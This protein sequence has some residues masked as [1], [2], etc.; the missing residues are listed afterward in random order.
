MSKYWLL[1]LSLTL[2]Y[3]LTGYVGLLMHAVGTNVTLMWLPTGIAVAF[4]FRAGYRYWPAVSLG[5]LLVNLSVGSSLSTSLGIM[6]GN[7]AG[8]LLTTVLLHRLKFHS[9]M[10]RPLDIGLLVLA[11]H[12]GMLVSATNGVVSLVQFDNLSEGYFKAWFCWW[13]G[14]SMG[15]IVAGPILLIAERIELEELQQRA[16]E[17]ACWIF[18]Y[19]LV[20]LGVFVWNSHTLEPAWA[21]AFLPFPLIA[22]AT[23]RFG[24]LGASLSVLLLS[25]GAAYGTSIQSG[26]FYRSE[27]SQQILMLW[28]YMATTSTLAWLIAALHA[29]QLRAVNINRILED[30]LREASLG[31]LLTDQNR[32]ITYVNEGFTRLTQYSQQ[33]LLGRDCM[34]LQGERTDSKTVKELNQVLNGSGHFDG[35][36]LNYR[37]D[38]TAFWNGLLISPI[39]N[40]R[41]ERIGFLGIQRDITEKKEADFSLKMSEARLRTILELEPE[42]VKIVSPDGRLM[43]MNPAGLVMVEADSIDQVRGAVLEVL[44]DEEYRDVFRKLHAYVLAGGSGHGEFPI[45][46][47]KGSRRW[48]ETHAVPY[49]DGDGEIV[50]QLAVTLDITNRKKAEDTIRRSEERHRGIIENSSTGT[51]LYEFDR[52]IP[53]DLPIEEQVRRI[54]T[55]GSIAIANDAQARMYGFERGEQLIGLR[56]IDLYQTLDNEA[57]N[58]FLRAMVQ[59]GYQIVDAVSE[60][61][62]RKGDPVV[63]SNDCLGT[64]ENGHLVRIWGSQRDITQQHLFEIA[65]RKLLETTTSNDLSFEEQLQRILELGCSHFGAEKGTVMRLDGE[66]YELLQEWTTSSPVSSPSEPIPSAKSVFETDISYS[67]TR[68]GL[69]H[70]ESSKPRTVPYSTLDTDLLMLMSDWIGSQLRLRST[71]SRQR[72]I[73]EN[74]PDLVLLLDRE[75]RVE[76]I[77]RMAP[78]VQPMEIIGTALPELVRPRDREVIEKCLAEVWQGR[79]LGQ[80]E[81]QYSFDGPELDDLEGRVT[82]VIDGSVVMGLVVTFTDVTARKRAELSVRESRDR[83]DGILT[84]IQVVVYSANI[85]GDAI[86]F[87]SD[88]CKAIYGLSAAEFILDPLHWQTSVH[89]EDRPKVEEAFAALQT[90]GAFEQEYR[91][92]RPDGSVRWVYDCG[93][94]ILDKVGVPIRLDGVVSDITERKWAEDELK[95]SELRYREMFKSNP[96]PMWVYDLKTLRFLAVN[97]AAIRHYGYSRDEFLAMTIADIRP[98]ED[99]AKLIENVSKVAN[100]LDR[101]GIWRHRTKS[102]QTIEVEV[103]SHPIQYDDRLAEVVLA[104]DVTERRRLEEQ[105]RISQQRFQA[106]VERSHDL[107]INFDTAGIIQFVNPASRVVLGYEPEEMIGRHNMSF[108]FPADQ[109]SKYREAETIIGKPRAEFRTE[110]KVQHK[111]GSWRIL[112]AVGINLLDEPALAGLVVNCRDITERK[113]RETRSTNERMLLELLTSGTPIDRV[114][115]EVALSSERLNPGMMCSILLLEKDGLHLHHAAA[116]SLP[117][118]YCQ[119]IDMFPIGPLAGSC[120]RAAVL[121]KSVITAEIRTDPHWKEYAELAEQNGLKAC[122]SVP[123]ISSGGQVLGT[124]AM[125]YSEPR[126]PTHLELASVERSAQLAVLAVER[127]QLLNSLQESKVQ[128]ERLVGNLPGMAYRCQN[129]TQWTMIYVS[130]GCEAVTGYLRDE[131]EQNKLVDYSDLIHSEDRDWLWSKCQLALERRVPCSNIYRIVDRAGEVRWVQERATGV[132]TEDGTLQFVDGFIQDISESRLADER[133]RNALREKEAMLKE[134]H[135]RVKNN[136]QIVSSLLNLQ[137]DKVKDSAV[138]DGL[139]DSQ[140]RVRSMALVH[141][142]LYSGNLGR[143]DLTEYLHSLCRHL[144]RS[145]GVDSAQIGLVLNVSNTSLDLEQAIPL[146]LIINELVSNSL[147]YAFPDGGSGQIQIEF[148]NLGEGHLHLVVSDNGVGISESID[149]KQL[150]SLGLQLVHDLAHQLAGSVKIFRGNGTQ[151]CITFPIRDSNQESNS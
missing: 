26:P 141:E 84:S 143:I 1:F 112:E 47:L 138:F 128:L 5:S 49:R 16:V 147:K 115:N 150:S 62:D 118:S 7:T 32:R 140:N 27:V 29:A 92:V 81:I 72:A 35:A 110:I 83:I 50:G 9:K 45:T 52:P 38:G 96:H 42:C 89:P 33:E 75:N 124:F 57:N 103:T 93:R 114:L 14:D 136:L 17:F 69:L 8:P 68:S 94:H 3:F 137:A 122:W 111:N 148:L 108:V 126:S 34:I 135:H 74:S 67:A 51:Y 109:K 145:Y 4:L 12:V 106:I 36:I 18:L 129:D 6:L 149:L 70:F 121:K 64:V 151:F 28:L 144:F 10:D 63:F 55:D 99:I 100:E 80:F 23:L 120:G 90:T 105:V 20:A 97:S 31:F 117:E 107:I 44:I 30:G 41:G 87:I 142:T 25:I 21:L 11:A 73:L 91:I 127:H 78:E 77:N 132:Y 134:I 65:I 95:A 61:F 104:N 60:E 123:L 40:K 19:V 102:G 130:S 119:T 146:G 24:I 53:I 139:R 39:T 37:K 54:V 56:A 86:L 59:N 58:S 13:A 88:H 113:E 76:F 15:V 48:L 66:A 46:S 116:P 22:W 71:M 98:M 131:L 2:A 133:V 79:S 101:A 82:P 85:R 43:E 125:Y